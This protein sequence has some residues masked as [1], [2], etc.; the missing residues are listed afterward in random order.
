LANA[1]TRST[2]GDTMKGSVVPIEGSK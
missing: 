1:L 2:A